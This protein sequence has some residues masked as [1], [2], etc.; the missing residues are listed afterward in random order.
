MFHHILSKMFSIPA[1]LH[2]TNH[3]KINGEI[4]VFYYVEQWFSNWGLGIPME[5]QGGAR[6]FTKHL[7]LYIYTLIRHNINH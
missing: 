2:R 7:R 5:P 4:D 6:G 1:T 3:R